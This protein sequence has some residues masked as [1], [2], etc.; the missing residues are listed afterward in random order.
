MRGGGSAVKSCV[1]QLEAVQQKHV[2]AAPTNIFGWDRTGGRTLL[3]IL[4]AA[5]IFIRIFSEILIL[6]SSRRNFTASLSPAS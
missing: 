5:K 4:Q 3:Q 6:G 2:Y 1:S